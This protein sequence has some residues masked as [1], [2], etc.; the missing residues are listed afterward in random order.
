MLEFRRRSRYR[1]AIPGLVTECEL[2]EIYMN[3]RSNTSSILFTSAL[4]ASLLFLRLPAA[5]IDP[6]R[7]NPELWDTGNHFGDLV[8][9]SVRE[10]WKAVPSDLLMLETNPPKASSDPVY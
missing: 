2:G 1:K 3:L 9:V 6:E 10:G 4:I 5:A 7:T 8:D